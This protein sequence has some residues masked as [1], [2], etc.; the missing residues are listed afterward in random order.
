MDE[1]SIAEIALQCSQRFTSI[2]R[3]LASHD[4]GEFS[5]TPEG[6]PSNTLLDIFARFRIWTGNIGALAR[7]KA[8]LDQRICHSHIRH[9][10]LRLLRQVIVV[11]DDCKSLLAW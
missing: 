6:F 9:E 3:T 5:G 7:G 4:S 11:L 2:K 1:Q 10:V 8:S